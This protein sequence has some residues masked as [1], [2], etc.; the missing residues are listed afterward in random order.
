MRVD[1]DLETL[2]RALLVAAVL[3]TAAQPFVAQARPSSP[4]VSPEQLRDRLMAGM[5]RGLS[6]VFDLIDVNR[7]GRITRAE[8]AAFAQR[9]GRQAVVGAESWGLADANRDG[10]IT[11]QELLAAAAA[12][13]NMIQQRGA[14]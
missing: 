5:Q 6:D 12:R 9:H 3:V 8:M 13:M 11:K 4:P 2:R 1:A 10:S 14:R 7:D